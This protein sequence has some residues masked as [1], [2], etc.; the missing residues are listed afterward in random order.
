MAILRRTDAQDDAEEGI[1]G[2][3]G[4]DNLFAVGEVPDARQGEIQGAQGGQEIQ[5]NPLENVIGL[6][7][8]FDVHD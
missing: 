8:Q 6:V 3:D 2:G 1:N 4:A 5:G 7:A